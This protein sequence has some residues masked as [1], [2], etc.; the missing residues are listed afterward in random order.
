MKVIWRRGGRLSAARMTSFPGLL[1]P[2]TSEGFLLK[3]SISPCQSAV[4]PHPKTSADS[5]IRMLPIACLTTRRQRSCNP[6]KTRAPPPFLLPVLFPF[7][8]LLFLSSPFPNE[9]FKLGLDI[10]LKPLS[11]DFARTRTPP[12]LVIASSVLHP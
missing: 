9:G 5:S 3:S 10:C 4:Q 2:V 7:C 8:P 12:H 11:L 1:S 6:Q